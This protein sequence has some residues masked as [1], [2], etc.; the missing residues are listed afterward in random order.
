MNYLL[1]INAQGNIIK[2]AIAD[3]N[4]DKSLKIIKNNESISEEEFVNQL[5]I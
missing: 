4:L 3:R 1:S 5:G 2:L